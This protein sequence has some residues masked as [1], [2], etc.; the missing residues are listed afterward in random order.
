MAETVKLGFVPLIDCAIPV[1]AHEMG[2]AAEEGLAL[3]LE[4]EASWAAVRDKLA[5]GLLDAAHLLAPLSLAMSAGL[6]G[7]PAVPVVAPMALGLG[8]NG[9]TVSKALY[10]RMTEAAP[11]VMAGPRGRS[12]RAL[13]KVI[14][15]DHAAGRPPLSFA[16]V[17]PFSSHTYELRLWLAD[18]GIDPDRD[19]NL[20]IVAPA[21]MAESL[22]M[23]WIDGYCVGE[24]W[25]LRAVQRGVGVVVA[26][27][28]DIWPN[29]PEKVLGLREDWA[30]ERPETTAALV[31]AL[32]RA[33]QWADAPE[34]RPALAAMLAD[35][36]YVGVSPEILEPALSGRPVLRP[37]APAEALDRHVFYRWQ[38]TYPWPSRAVWL[39]DRMAEAG[40]ASLSP[41]AAAALARRVFRDD[42]Y[43]GA[44]QSL[45]VAVPEADL[46]AIGSHDAPHDVPARGG[47]T[48][49]LGPDRQL[50]RRTFYPFGHD[51]A[52]RET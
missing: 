40:Q 15:A 47:G 20:G 32:V 24:P 17:F 25:N 2:F 33:A 19:V 9:I 34:N 49:T 37:D 28:A 21:R 16:S 10:E 35:M 41:A 31:R 43:A 23:G 4:R 45:G 26:T 30:A 44:V 14:E 6:G 3:D 46:T 8:G 36:R 7:S 27:K 22:H 42:L 1:V 5:Y 12:A 51:A 29:A 13:K 50:G 39:L 11:E 48:V 18:A 52:S 38:A